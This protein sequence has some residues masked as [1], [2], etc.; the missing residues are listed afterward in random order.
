MNHTRRQFVG[1]AAALTATAA[2]HIPTARAATAPTRIALA[3]FMKDDARVASFRKGIAAMK[4]LP[5]SDRK[6]WFWWAATHAYNDA[7][8]KD[9]LKRD[10]KLAKVNKARYFNQCPH[11]GQ[12]SADFLLWHRAYVYYFERCLRDAAGDPTLAVPYWDYSREDSR[13]FP[14]I[15]QARWLDDA[16]TQEN[17]LYH[18]NRDLGFTSGRFEL[19]SP[20]CVAAKTMAVA[21]FFTE[22]GNTG[23]A[24]D[25][26]DKKH[27]QLGL[28]EQRP[29]ND[30]H[31]TVGGVVGSTNGAMADIPTAAFDPVFWVHHANIDRMWSVWAAT[32]GKRWGPMPPDAWLD[33]EPWLFVDADGREVRES[34]RFYLD[35]ANLDMRYD[36]DKP[37]A[38]ALAVPVAAVRLGAVTAAPPAAQSAPAPETSA[39]PS[40]GGFGAS[41]SMGPMVGAPPR[42]GAAAPTPDMGMPGD[43]MSVMEDQFSLFADTAPIFVSP[44]K[45]ATRVI[46]ASS[47]GETAGHPPANTGAPT[48]AASGGGIAPPR[49]PANARVLL[50]L[51]DITFGRVPSSGFAVYLDREGARADNDANYVGLIDLFGATHADMAGMS[52]MKAVQRFDVTRIVAGAAGNFTLRVEPY[53][54][55]VT[56]SGAPAPS[57]PDAVKIGSVRFVVVS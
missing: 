7:L 31:I 35:R 45:P 25:I 27:T 12:S 34:R 30:I 36:T 29:H 47:L 3:D 11:F 16:K 23:F 46:A 37:G 15:F 1:T 38:V 48:R 14:E 8:F 39:A 5:P 26:L 4:A 41:K 56:K 52:G 55:L 40:G 50:E 22:P 51:S 33:E 18:P 54:L 2:L 6:S 20:V 21:N 42:A 32:P 57:R 10:R 17:P 44:T 9:A 28:M 13:S 49:I 43:M 19:A 53:A 24:G